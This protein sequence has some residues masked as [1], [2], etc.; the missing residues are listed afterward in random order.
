MKD[1]DK[2]KEQLLNELVE[3]RNQNTELEALVA[4][5]KW[6]KDATQEALKYAENIIETVREPL[7]VLDADLKVLS[8]N[9][10]FYDTFKVTPGKTIGSFFYD[11]GNRQWDIPGLRELL[12]G[13]LPRKNEVTNYEVKHDFP[14]IGQKTMLIN[15][16]QILRK[17]IGSTMILLAIEDIT[18]LKWAEAE[19]ESLINELQESLAEI[20]SIKTMIPVCAMNKKD[21]TEAIKQHYNNIIKKGKCPECLGAHRR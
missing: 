19:R 21:Y 3:L 18:E 11:L 13:I 15:A 10:S 2:T 4:E 8:A 17:D 5:L 12:E 14:I 6:S 9:R 1:K 16:R 20:K 7:L